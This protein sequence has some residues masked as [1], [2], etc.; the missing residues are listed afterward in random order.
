MCD[1][2]LENNK[3]I[4]ANSSYRSYEEQKKTYNTYLKLY[5]QKY[6]SNYVA[7]PGFSEH[8]TGLAVDIASKNNKIFKNSKEYKWIL[9]N[10]YKYGFILR[11]TK[12]NQKITGYEEE[13][14]HFRY[15]GLEIAKYIYENNITYEEYYVMFIDK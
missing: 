7:L 2:A 5:G 3:Y 13:S 14:W 9:E 15:V 10:S 6:V 11:Y 8:Q 4:L 12:S 1:A